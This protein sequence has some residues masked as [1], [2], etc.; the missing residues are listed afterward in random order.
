M[1]GTRYHHG[2]LREVLVDTAVGAVREGGA[3]AL[4]LRDLARRVGVSHNAAYRHFAGRDDVLAAVAAR[5]MDQLT[6]TM[7]RR[8]DGVDTDDAVLR[9][10]RRLAAVGR[11]YVEFAVDEPNLFRLTFASLSSVLEP[12]PY[13]MLSEVLDDLVA[14]GFL[15][16][17]ARPGAEATCWSA[18]HGFSVL[19][20]EGALGAVA[21]LGGDA[22]EPRAAPWDAELEQVLFSIDRSYAATTGATVVAGELG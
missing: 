22:G 1:S 15:A 10:R 20:I 13:L 7:S 12:G 5:G 8:L 4:A 9:A 16:P 21:D 14:V 2:N 3:D 19:V 17:S 11:A 18:M 6:A